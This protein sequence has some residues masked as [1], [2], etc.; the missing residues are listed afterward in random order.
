VAGEYT[1]LGTSRL[2]LED[3][4]DAV[5]LRDNLSVGDLAWSMAALGQ[6]A[7]QAPHPRIRGLTE[8]NRCPA[9]RDVEHLDGV[10]PAGAWQTP[11]PSTL[12]LDLDLRTS[13]LERPVELATAMET[14]SSALLV[15]FSLSYG[16]GALLSEIGHL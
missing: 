14:R 10:H 11:H 7:T 5:D 2:A 9:S 4:C 8:A 3:R 15:A 12:I 6:A 16:P 13:L 1:T